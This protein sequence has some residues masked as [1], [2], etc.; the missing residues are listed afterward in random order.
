MTCQVGIQCSFWRCFHLFP[1]AVCDFATPIESFHNYK[2][3][4]ENAGHENAGHE[5]TVHAKA[6]QK[7][8]LEAANV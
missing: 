7:T 4:A 2:R 5:I 3:G 1:A 8:S 6:R